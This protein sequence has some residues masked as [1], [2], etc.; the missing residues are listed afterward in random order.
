MINKTLEYKEMQRTS[1]Y[2]LLL[3][4][5]LAA[6][7]LII[8]LLFKSSAVVSDSVHTLSD[9]ITTVIVMIGIK[10]SHAP[11]DKNH[12]YGHEKI[13]AVFST[14][15]AVILFI[16]G[17]MLMVNAI[18]GLINGSTPMIFSP[19]LIIITLIGIFSKELMFHYTMFYAKKYNS[20]SLR[21]DAWHH[22]SDSISS[23]A[24]LIGVG[25]ALL[26]P[27]LAYLEQAAT[28]IVALLIAK[29]AFDIYINSIDK[30]IDKAAD[31]ETVKKM[32]EIVC[33]IP[34]VE[35]IDNLK[36][37]LSTYKIYVD[38]EIA[39][40]GNLSVIK[41][42]EIAQNVHDILENKYTEFNIKHINVHVN[43]LN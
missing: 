42:H 17:I 25:I 41:A 29:V 32:S 43:P 9:V 8:G 14:I 3:N 22:R 23:I 12:N 10:I 4:I 38:I 7:T 30:L 18:N 5:F 2:T 26:F 28:I 24:V 34:G 37:R 13:E 27:Q 6:A 33:K 11:A 36:T 19:L 31:Y 1:L 35:R 21:A 39:V 16:T 20:Q 15:L 40:N